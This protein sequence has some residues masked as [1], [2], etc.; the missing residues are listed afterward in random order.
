MLSWFECASRT[1]GTGYSWLP[2]LAS[3]V[4]FKLLFV[5]SS[6]FG[7]SISRIV[8]YLFKIFLD[9]LSKKNSNRLHCLLHSLFG[10]VFNS[11]S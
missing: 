7:D 1:V 3:L 5:C 9:F 10:H 11:K 6:I 8:A 2:D 4:D